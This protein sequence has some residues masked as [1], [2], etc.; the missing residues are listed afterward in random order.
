MPDQIR[1]RS[2]A[3]PSQ[4]I[5]YEEY[6]RNIPGF[7]PSERDS[8]ILLPKHQ[9]LETSQLNVT[10]TFPTSQVIQGEDA[11]IIFEK[12]LLELEQFIQAIASQSQYNHFN[13]SMIL[14]RDCLVHTLRARDIATPQTL[15]QKVS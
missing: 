10:N 3:T 8:V 14:L 15:V 1:L 4:M 13:A 6:A 7:L 9:H 11:N 12:L 2:T 5:V